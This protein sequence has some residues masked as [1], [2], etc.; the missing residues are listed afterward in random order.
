MLNE[1]PRESDWRCFRADEDVLGREIFV[2]RWLDEGS[3][4]RCEAAVA[5]D[6]RWVLSV[7]LR[8]AR[9]RFKRG[10]LT[11]VEGRMPPGM[12]HVTGPGQTLQADFVGPCDFLHFYLAADFVARRAADLSRP[13]ESLHD[14]AMHD[15]L[16]AQ[17][18]RTL[19][20][21]DALCGRAYQEGV[22]ETIFARLFMARPVRGTVNPLPK[23]RLRRVREFVAEH[24]S[25]RITLPEL[26]AA[27]GLS[28]MHFAAQFRAASGLR[29]HHWVLQ[30]RVE[31]AK[32][33]IAEENMPLAQVA[34]CAGFQTQS[35]LSTVFKRFTGDTPGEWRRQHRPA[36]A[37]RTRPA[38]RA[39]LELRPS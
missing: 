23:W 29:P 13:A 35:H 10:A 25:E 17:L 22:A 7:S 24:I 6:D 21:S 34:L 16:A 4:P 3:H 30:E 11:L 5:P 20:G 31:F 36:T 12:L 8:T 1:L 33:A 32:A 18:G 26:A 27:A 38:F 37:P 2:S 9:V 15:P 39:G 14:L 28:R 19:V